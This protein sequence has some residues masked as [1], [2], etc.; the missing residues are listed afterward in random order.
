[1]ILP[2][3]S[4]DDSHD[5]GLS[6]AFECSIFWIM[7][8]L[9]SIYFYN[10]VYIRLTTLLRCH[11]A[12]FGDIPD[13]LMVEILDILEKLDDIWLSLIL[14]SQFLLL[15][16]TSLTELFLINLKY[17]V[18][19]IPLRCSWRSK[20]IIYIFL[21]FLFWSNSMIKRRWIAQV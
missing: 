12:L 15:S 10:D 19:I 13:G 21:C 18:L 3:S 5:F 6:K 17:Y 4:K 2:D 8:G 14:N 7:F 16:K 11:C 9:Y 1:M 20:K